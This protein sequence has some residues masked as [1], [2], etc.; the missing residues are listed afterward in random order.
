MRAKQR[1]ERVPRAK[2]HRPACWPRAARP[3]YRLGLL[4]AGQI[5]T[6]DVPLWAAFKKGL[7]ELGYAG[8]EKGRWAG[9]R[10]L[11]A[12]DLGVRSRPP[13][14]AT[15]TLTGEREPAEFCRHQFCRG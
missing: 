15:T 1:R 5:L 7:H 13:A 9:E 3:V 2:W 8:N 11:D 10:V 4:S 12:Y 6:S 14:V